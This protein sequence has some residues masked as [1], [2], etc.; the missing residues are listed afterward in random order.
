[1]GPLLLAALLCSLLLSAPASPLSP[2]PLR[3]PIQASSSQHTATDIPYPIPCFLHPHPAASKESL[4]RYT[5]LRGGGT[6]HHP[7]MSGVTVTAQ[8]LKNNIGMVKVLDASWYLKNM[9]RAPGV[10]FNA[11]EDF[12]KRR[13]QGALYFDIDEVCDKASLLPHMLPTAKEFSASVAKLGISRGDSVVVYDGKG[14]FSSPRAWMMFKIF[15]HDRVSILDGGFPAWWAQTVPTLRPSPSPSPTT[16]PPTTHP[17][18]P[19][20]HLEHLPRRHSLACVH[21]LIPLR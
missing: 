13:V 6:A 19:A 18:F 8:W 12:T 20:F 7:A 17:S 21:I 15:G 14:V 1:M 10:P 16:P 4:P 5:R 9:E 11:K 2:S 3:A